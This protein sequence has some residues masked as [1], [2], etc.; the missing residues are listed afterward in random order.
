MSSGPKI[1]DLVKITDILFHGHIYGGTGMII[2]I[3]ELS[4]DA[5]GEDKFIVLVD[6][7][8][9][10]MLLDEFELIS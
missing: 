10:N 5:Y 4:A 9:Y 1:G 8:K 3:V 2:D 7:D 6:E